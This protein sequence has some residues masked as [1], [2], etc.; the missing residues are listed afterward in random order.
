V[1]LVCAKAQAAA[2]ER[3]MDTLSPEEADI[4]RRGRNAHPRAVPKNADPGE[5]A[6]ATALEALAGYLYLSGRNE[7]LDEIMQAAL[8]GDE[9]C[10]G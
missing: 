7:R 4:V 5:Y 8:V 2:L 6:R 1:G 3:V 9:S 10:Q